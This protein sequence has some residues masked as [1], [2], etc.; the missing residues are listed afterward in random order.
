MPP[1]I[2]YICKVGVH[3]MLISLSVDNFVNIEL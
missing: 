3:S 2:Y 1:L